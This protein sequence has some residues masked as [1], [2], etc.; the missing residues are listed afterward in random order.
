MAG[1]NI[2]GEKEGTPMTLHERQSSFISSPRTLDIG[3]STSKIGFDG[4]L[5]IVSN[6]SVL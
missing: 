3:I 5:D 2:D 4:P 6:I 1:F